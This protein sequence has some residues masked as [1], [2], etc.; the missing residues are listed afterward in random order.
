MRALALCL[1][2]TCATAL[3]ACATGTP[4]PWA[5]TGTTDTGGGDTNFDVPDTGV[6]DTLVPDTGVPDTGWDTGAPDSTLDPD[7]DPD[8]DPDPEPEAPCVSGTAS[9][10]GIC[11]IIDECGCGSG[12]C[13]WNYDSTTCLPYE[14]CYTVTAGTV[15]HGGS[16]DPTG[17]SG[18]ECAPNAGCLSSDGGVT[19]TCQQWCETDLDCPSSYTCTIPVVVDLSSLGCPSEVDMP[20]DACSI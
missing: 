19:G 7:A 12:W 13:T 1:L 3:A 20:Y 8:P 10:G 14:D 11:N 5:D 2:V 4:D 18:V 17:A 16:C 15:T 6:P 9:S